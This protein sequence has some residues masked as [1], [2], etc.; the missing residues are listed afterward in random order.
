MDNLN[1]DIKVGKSL[2]IKKQAEQF[3][4][5]QI[6]KK[7]FIVD[8]K[9]L[10]SDKVRQFLKANDFLYS[11]CKYLYII[12]DNRLTNKQ[13][14]DQNYF[15]IVSKLWWV[16]WWELA[17]NYHTGK[18]AK[19]NTI[20]II[21]STKCW[22]MYLGDNQNY[23]IRYQKS[24][25][26]RDIEKVNM[27][28]AKL[29]I[30]KPT[31]Y[32]INNFNE[33]TLEN[34]DFNILLTSTKF[35]LT[36]IEDYIERWANITSLSKMALWYK[37]N[38]NPRNYSLI[39]VALQK[40]GKSFK[41]PKWNWETENSI[42]NLFNSSL[43]YNTEND[44]DSN[45]KLIRFEKMIEKMDKQC[46]NYLWNNN[47][48]RIKEVSLKELLINI[49]ENM[50]HDSYHSLTIEQYN[51]TREDI[52]I[53]KNPHLNEKES[54]IIEDKLAIKGYI[55]AYKS[56]VEQIWIDYSYWN[57]IDKRFITNLNW[58]LFSEYSKH[59]WFTI[60]NKYREEN[61]WI[62]WSSHHPTDH[63]LVNEYMDI[64][65]KYINWIKTNCIENK[66]KKAIMTHFLFVYIHPFGD[67]NWRTARFLMNHTLWSDKLNWV[68]INS[69][70]KDEYIDSLKAWSENWDITKFTAFITK[71]LIKN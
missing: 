58:L 31:S 13:T 41:Y 66:I 9:Q 59:R 24:E 61:V 44:I 11:P 39:K 23:T 19:V 26:F 4:E 54:D 15:N 32:L 55:K 29:Y 33:N 56:I 46:T 62:S 70:D 7:E 53:L 2:S 36:D 34:E 51:V 28:W 68:T 50:V 21:T 43:D 18:T 14:L 1:K 25:K 16:V 64:F 20:D 65:T 67:W 30:E 27:S 6:E 57:N 22:Q 5:K 49:E 12:K 48:K 45:P 40:A 52:E 3:L 42:N 17:L 60:E 69:N 8:W 38:D 35:N 37:N 47:L 63:T 71:Y 10:P